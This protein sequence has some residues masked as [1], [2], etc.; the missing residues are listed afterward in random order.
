MELARVIGNLVSSHKVSSLEGVKFLLVQPLNENLEPVGE[1]A[2]A[3][4][5]THQA[6]D[7]DL[8]FIESGREAAMALPV[9][10]NPSDLSIIGIV[11]DVYKK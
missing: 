3:T 6:G 8:V 1:A 2:V 10:F 9:S 5:V 7:G 4:D 11:D